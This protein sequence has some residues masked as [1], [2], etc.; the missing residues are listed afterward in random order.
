[1]KWFPYARL[2]KRNLLRDSTEN[3]YT[4]ADAADV[5][6]MVEDAETA[7]EVTALTAK[8]TADAAVTN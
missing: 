4:A 6:V 1:V 3:M 8:V 2:Q 7:K 5:E